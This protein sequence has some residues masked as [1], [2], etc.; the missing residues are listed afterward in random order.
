[1]NTKKLTCNFLPGKIPALTLIGYMQNRKLQVWLPL[2]LSAAM[3]LGIFFG[4]KMRDGFPAK[5]FFYTEK[6]NP[7]KEVIDIINRK[8][9]DS[10]DENKLADTAIVAMLSKLDPH[11]AYIA[12]SELEEVNEEINGSF[13][14]IG[15]E[16]NIFS[17]SMHIINVFKDGPAFKAGLQVGDIILKANDSLLTGKKLKSETIRKSMRGPLGSTLQLQILRAAKLQTVKMQRGNIPIFSMEAAYMLN[18]N[19][20]YIKLDKFTKQTYREFMLA[21]ESLK[22]KGLQKLVL[23]LRGNGGGVLDEAVEIADEFLAGEKL[24]TYTEGL[25]VKKKEYRCR[26]QGQFEE[27]KLVVL[28]DERSASA[29]EILLGALQDWDRATIIGRRSFGKGLVQEQFDLSNKAALRLTVAR[30]FTPVGRSIQRNFKNGNNAYFNEVAIRYTNGSLIYADSSKNDSSKIYKTKNGKTIFGGGGIS[31]DIFIAADTGRIDSAFAKLYFKGVLSDFGYLYVI[32]NPSA[33]KLYKTSESFASSFVLN[34]AD[35]KYFS[36]L[37]L[38]D[39]I[40]VS[41][42]SENKRIYIS[43]MLK[44]SIARQ[45]FRTEGYYE[46]M[47]ADDK[48]VQ[49][50]LEI[51][52]K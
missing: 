32:Q 5:N 31:P 39:S 52:N 49:K 12:A 45:L 28:A 21:L 42:I 36:T 26:R 6:R 9:V 1:L 14:G 17:D 40:D 30:Y 20:G 19:T 43:R 11:S 34:D 27:G 18:N 33:S 44:A 23:D 16:Y 2:M 25:H 22:K 41:N 7:L 51:L 15:I 37:A 10:I 48:A 35:W 8:Y 13:F 3:A 50:A 24:I 47:N 38:K 46:V 29:S 4:F